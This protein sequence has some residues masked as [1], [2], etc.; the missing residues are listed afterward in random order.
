MVVVVDKSTDDSYADSSDVP[1]AALIWTKPTAGAKSS[2]STFDAYAD[3]TDDPWA[4]PAFIPD[5]PQTRTKP[6]LGANSSDSTDDSWA[7]PAFI[8]V[9]DSWAAP[10]F[11]PV[12]PPIMSTPSQSCA[13]AAS[14]YIPDSASECDESDIDAPELSEDVNWL[15][16]KILGHHKPHNNNAHTTIT[17]DNT[18]THLGSETIHSLTASNPFIPSN[19]QTIVPVTLIWESATGDRT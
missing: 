8:P 3:N 6:T 10:A 9:D 13:W 14:A 11:I 1:R 4:A 2:D 19:G 5:P 16:I 18:T 7:A 17:P 12:S 15:P